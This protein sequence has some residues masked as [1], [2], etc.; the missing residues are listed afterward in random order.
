MKPVQTTNRIFLALLAVAL[1]AALASHLL[2]WPD[3][4]TFALS[5]A[6]VIP[7]A[8][9]IGEATEVLAHK[10]GSGIGGL[11]NATFG[12]AAELILAFAALRAGKIQVVKA[13]LTGSIIGNLLL[14]VGLSMLLGG[15]GRAKQTYNPTAALTGVSMMF[16]A[17][18]ALGLPDLY[19]LAKGVEAEP[20]LVSMSVGI[21][22]VMLV[23]YALSLVFSIKTHAHLYTDER[24]VVEGVSWS[25]TR[26]VTVLAAAAAGTALMAELL[27]HALE[28]ASAKLH[29]TETFIGV[30]VVAIVGNAAEH[31]TAV[32]M[33]VKDRMN[34]AF[35][36]AVESSKQ[37]AL[38][39]APV[40]VLASLAVGPGP[41]TL[42]F[43]HLEVVAVAIGVGALTLTALD[44]ESNWL[45]GAML[46]ALYAMLAVAFYHTTP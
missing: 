29:L 41:M 46:L 3:V 11:L 22:L 6:A 31:A 25:T 21:A 17:V 7:L 42:E 24:E 2:H 36:I 44:G 27:V 37:I 18:V 45:E 19:H 1:P 35:N 5:C 43:T 34:L 32:V 28:G 9:Y 40:L 15:L 30:V 23:I 39:V 26:A 20:H 10:V 33:A 38:L 14:I 4:V 16:L 12:N 8:R 13:S